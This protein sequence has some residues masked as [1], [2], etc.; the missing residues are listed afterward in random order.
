MLLVN[1]MFPEIKLASKILLTN[2]GFFCPFELNF[3]ITYKCNSRC[4]ICKIWQKKHENELSLEEIKK[5]TKKIDFVQWVRL[6]GGEPFLREDYIEVVKAFDKNLPNLILLSTP[7]NAL[8]PNV[9]YKK[10][11]Q[12]LKFFRKK[13]VITVSL[14]GPKKIHNKIRGIRTAWD[15]S[16]ETYQRLKELEKKHKNFKAFFGYTISPYNLGFFKQTLEGVKKIIPGITANDFHVNLFQTSEIYYGIKASKLNKSYFNR[17]K[18]EIDKI[19][20]L[21][22]KKLSLIEIGEIKYLQLAKKYLK[23]GKVPINC[24]IFNLSCFIDP[25]GN[26]FPCT[27]FNRKLGN[28]R[29]SNYDLM[30]ILSS[31]ES[32]RVKTEILE[33]KC[34]QCWTPCEAH[35]MIFSNFLKC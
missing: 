29:D 15:S 11:E 17:A 2:L 6:T 19:L 22:I 9:I 26:V 4:K 3:A 20:N 10:V 16:I 7:T 30:N 24:N 35:Q 23:T 12:T 8:T 5:I 18:A 14:D 27:I 25:F 21:K 13:Y 34:P 1:S 33:G 32:K 28:L 31:E